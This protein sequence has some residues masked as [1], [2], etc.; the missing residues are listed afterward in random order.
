[1]RTVIS[2][3]IIHKRTVHTKREAASSVV[4][5]EVLGLFQLRYREEHR[6]RVHFRSV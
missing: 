1:M 5:E 2:M 3:A 6:F 4:S